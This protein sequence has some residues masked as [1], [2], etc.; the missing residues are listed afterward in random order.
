MNK[1][2]EGIAFCSLQYGKKTQSSQLSNLKIL[3]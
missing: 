1:Y 3:D 2:S